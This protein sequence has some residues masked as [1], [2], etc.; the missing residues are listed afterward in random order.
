M[1]TLAE[2][3][4]VVNPFS[5]GR[6][7]RRAFNQVTSSGSTPTPASPSTS[8]PGTK[9]QQVEQPV[10][11]VAETPL[12]NVN[13]LALGRQARKAFDEVGEEE[14]LTLACS[15]WVCKAETRP[16]KPQLN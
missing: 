6:Q 5:L 15:V 13:P 3:A 14:L 11:P 2:L 9:R 7:A 4:H 10:V 1:T 8:S 12:D 16:V